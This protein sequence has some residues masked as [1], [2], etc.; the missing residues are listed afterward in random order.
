MFTVHT[1]PPR[2]QCRKR[3]AG[4]LSQREQV[5]ERLIWPCWQTQ[6]QSSLLEI[7]PRGQRS[8]RA[9][10][11]SRARQHSRGFVF[12]PLGICPSSTPVV[13]VRRETRASDR[14]LWCSFACRFGADCLLKVFALFAA[15]RA[16]FRED[17]K[18]FLGLLNVTGFDIELAKVLASSLVIW[19]Q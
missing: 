17:G 14:P 5:Q 8:M 1:T 15:A 10:G 18:L 19:L 6:Q 2:L 7:R 12:V 4:R 9:I 13:L 11:G 16:E 3:A